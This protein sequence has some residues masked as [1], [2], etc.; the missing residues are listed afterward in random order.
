MTVLNVEKT[1][2]SKNVEKDKVIGSKNDNCVLNI[3]L[4]NN[5]TLFS[6]EANVERVMLK[7]V[8]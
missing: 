8:L 6:D 2:F 1:E 3:V 5:L 4:L 7:M